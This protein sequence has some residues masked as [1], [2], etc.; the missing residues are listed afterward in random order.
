M[1]TE[2]DDPFGHNA[3]CSAL[4]VGSAHTVGLAVHCSMQFGA[5]CWVAQAI[6][7]NSVSEH[8]A[9]IVTSD[10]HPIPDHLNPNPN[11]TIPQP[12]FTCYIVF[13]FTEQNMF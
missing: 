11:L 12:L 9:T 10:F 5:H 1:W 3:I 4:S 8:S 6:G 2:G 7:N 13:F